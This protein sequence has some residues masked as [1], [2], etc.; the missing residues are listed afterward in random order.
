[1]AEVL[2]YKTSV[3]PASRPAVLILPVTLTAADFNTA[4]SSTPDLAAKLQYD[5]I[6][7]RLQVVPTNGDPEDHPA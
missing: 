6:S 4:L 7:G 1:M 3:V 5:A 2:N